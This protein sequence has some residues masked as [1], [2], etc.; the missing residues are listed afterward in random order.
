MIGSTKSQLARVLYVGATKEANFA[1]AM[2]GMKVMKAMK[3]SNQKRNQASSGKQLVVKTEAKKG[4]RAIKPMKCMK[5]MTTPSPK[6]KHA[7][8]KKHVV[9]NMEPSG[10]EQGRL[11]QAIRTKSSQIQPRA[12][13]DDPCMKA[14]VHTQTP[15]SSQTQTPAS[16][17]QLSPASNQKQTPAPSQSQTP[18]SSRKQP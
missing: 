16:G 7:S 15:A 8:S 1:E 11:G 13:S 14:A 10:F 4:M 3:A 9:A 6:K 17:Q 5:A 2:N 18:A 12:F